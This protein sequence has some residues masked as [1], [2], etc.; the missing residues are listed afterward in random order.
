[1]TGVG[2]ADGNG[3]SVGLAVGE[4]VVVDDGDGV[5]TVSAIA[6]VLAVKMPNT[7]SAD[8]IARRLVLELNTAN[9]QRRTYP[10][11]RPS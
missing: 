5:G 11:W 10:S 3:D 6:A 4:G 7:V 9:R 1:M 2:D 8:A